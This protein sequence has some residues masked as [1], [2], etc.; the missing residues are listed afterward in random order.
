MP[1][2]TADGPV[3][4]FSAEAAA[5]AYTELPPTFGEYAGKV[6][7]ETSEMMH[8]ALRRA[9]Y[10]ESGWGTLGRAV[11]A[12]GMVEGGAVP[13]DY[14]LTPDLAPVASPHMT[15]QEATARHP[16][17]A[18]AAPD[19]FT[20]NMPQGVVDALADSKRNEIERQAVFQRY[21]QAFVA[22][23]FSDA[24]GID[25]ARSGQYGCA[26]HSRCW[27]GSGAGAA[28]VGSRL[29][30]DGTGCGGCNRWRDWDGSWR[31]APLRLERG[32][33]R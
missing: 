9:T 16:E 26:I 32:R 23:K 7:G 24:H 4:E 10:D 17:V 11:M 15:K 30:D 1:E 29:A 5:K 20:E 28:R 8:G 27:R 13:E 12:A 19:L 3:P 33:R 14:G 31:W 2:L 25:D 6:I 22:D 18:A 21:E